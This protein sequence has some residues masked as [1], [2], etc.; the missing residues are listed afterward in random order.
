[1]GF[2]PLRITHIVHSLYFS[3][4]GIFFWWSQRVWMHFAPLCMQ[5]GAPISFFLHFGTNSSP[6]KVQH[7]LV[8][9]NSVKIAPNWLFFGAPRGSEVL[10]CWGRCTKISTFLRDLPHPSQN[11]NFH[12]IDKIAD[13]LQNKR[14]FLIAPRD[15]HFLGASGEYFKRTWARAT[16]FLASGYAPKW[17]FSLRIAHIAHSLYFSTKGIF[18]W[19]SQRVWMHFGPLC[20]QLRAPISFFL[21]FGTNSSPEKVQHFLVSPN[22][23]KM[24]PN[25]LFFGAPTGS[26]VLFAGAVAPKS[27]LF[28]RTYPTP[29]KTEI[30]TLSTKSKTFY[31]INVFFW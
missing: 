16:P 19:W 13:F 14:F 17:V 18:F 2:F 1:M 31:R 4:K 22:S 29:L 25:G 8:S 30:S 10:L 6:E 20:M 3:R 15:W 7:F 28:W 12:L 27:A 5:L 11:W 9:P 24:A 23:I 21:L 26:E